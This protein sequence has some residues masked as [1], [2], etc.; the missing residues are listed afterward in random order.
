MLNLEAPKKVIEYT[1]PDSL[2]A[3]KTKGPTRKRLRKP[4]G[5]LQRMGNGPVEVAS[6]YTEKSL[7]TQ[8]EKGSKRLK[9]SSSRRDD[10]DE[11]EDSLQKR[12]GRGSQANRQLQ[13][14]AKLMEDSDHFSGVSG[15]R[16]VSLPSNFYEVIREVFATFWELEFEETEV[17][18]A[19]FAKITSA[20]CREFRLNSFA[21]RSYCLAVIKVRGCR[22][23]QTKP[24]PYNPIS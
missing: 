5:K 2:G 24:D 11:F 6:I 12:D 23:N 16:A 9:G 17:T 14:G 15:A 3:A 10:E 19:F 21:E 13:G 20:N 8:D 18:W 7:P 4:S 22:G 1:G